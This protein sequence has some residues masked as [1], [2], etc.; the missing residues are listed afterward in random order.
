MGISATGRSRL[1]H[2]AVRRRERVR[3]PRAH[4]PP[5]RFSSSCGATSHT[6]VPTIADGLEIICARGIALER[7][8][9]GGLPEGRPPVV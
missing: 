1:V 9:T 6:F 7:C 5:S 2:S 8:T 4:L 3:L